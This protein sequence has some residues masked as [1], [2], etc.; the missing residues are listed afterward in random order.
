MNAKGT[1]TVA[2]WDEKDFSELPHEMKITKADIEFTVTGDVEGKAVVQYVM[3]YSK[4]NKSDPHN[5][6]AKYVGLMEFSGKISGRT[7]TFVLE[8]NG[9]FKSGNADSELKI[10]AD[11]GTADLQN[12]K[13]H[14]KYSANKDGFHIELDYTL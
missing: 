6:S 1:C 11:S 14:G 13:G 12:I 7:G 3:F 10:I 8:D 2:K 5:S 9:I 4:H